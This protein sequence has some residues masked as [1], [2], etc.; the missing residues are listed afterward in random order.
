MQWFR[1]HDAESASRR[2]VRDVL[3]RI[4][5]LEQSP[6]RCALASESGILQMEIR[7]LLFGRRSGRYRILFVV[8]GSTV[9]VLHIRHAA[10]DAISSWSFE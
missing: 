9:H 3:A 5:T 8:E 7:Q 10:R 6:N 2:W 4:S 1:S